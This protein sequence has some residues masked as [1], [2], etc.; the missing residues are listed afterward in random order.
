MMKKFFTL[1]ALVAISFSSMAQWLPQASGFT[2]PSRGIQ[3]MHAASD[4]VVWACAYD[5]SGGGATI[6]EF[7]RTTNGGDLWTPGQVLGGT[8]YGLGNICALDGNIAYVALYK[9]SGN[10]DNTCGVYKTVNGGLTWTQLPGALQGSTSFANNVFFWNEQEG[11]CHGDVRDGY[12]EIYT[13]VNGGTTWQRVPQTSITGGTPASGEGGWTSVI[14]TTGENTVMFGTNKGKVYISD[15]RGFTWRVTSTG[16]TP[17][18]NGGINEIAFTDPDNGIAIQTIAPVAY[19]RTSDGGATWESFT[20]TGPFLTNDLS[21]VP[22][23][24]GTYISTGAAEGFTGIAYSY[25]KG[26]TWAFFPDTEG[27]QFLATDW[28]NITTGWCGA[29]NESNTV[30]GMYKFNGSLEEPLPPTNLQGTVTGGNDVHLTWDAPGGGSVDGFFDDFEDYEDFTLSFS[31]WTN[32]DVDG[33]ETYVIDG[34]TWLNGGDP[35]AYIIFNPMS[36]TP[37]LEETIA[38][39]GTK[40]AA[41]FASVTPPNNDWL[42]SP[43]IMINAGDIADFFAKSYTDQYGLERFKVGISTTGTDPAD[44]TIISAGSYITAPA[45]AYEEFSYDLSAYSGQE[46]YVGIQCVS[47]DA[48]IFLVDDFYVGAP[49]KRHVATANIVSAASSSR[50]VIA[51]NNQHKPNT[52][53]GGER[54]MLG[55]NVWRNGV[56]IANQIADTFYDDMDLANGGYQYL[57][58]AV[59]DN[60]ESTPAGPVEIEITG[61][62][63]LT[64]IIL[65]FEDQADFDLTFG[66]WEAVDL[67]GGATYGFTGITFPHSGEPMAYIAF[68]PAA[69]EPAVTDMEPHGGVRLGACFASVPPAVNDDW[70]ISPQVTLGESPI[71][72]MW[73][74]SYTAEYGLE[75]YNVLVSTTDNNPS[76]FTQIAGPIEAPATAW[77]YV[78]YDLADYQGADVYV[79]IQCVSNDKFIFLI[80]DVAV[81]FITSSGNLPS[82]ENLK[83]YPNPV[84]DVLNINAGVEIINAKLYNVSGQLVYE[85]NGNSN[86][87]R[88]STSVMPSGLYI[89]NIATKQGTL[90]RKVSIQ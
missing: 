22:G 86:E 79:A 55:Y 33:S 59:Y 50:S 13:T 20:P 80:D 58:T 90:T 72:S 6:N 65:D 42:I 19:R 69:T 16:I 82:V 27:I 34:Y 51:G 30:G 36:T 44:F 29:F 11:M 4:Q 70:M 47:N 60:G 63:N 54:E 18:T 37:V 5:G 76:S 57:V 32:I 64:S 17:A 12:F 85:S 7:T 25:D 10:Q 56:M 67:D 28:V 49:G 78:E 45:D 23:T 52:V 35:Q 39:S 46:V 2:T 74:K 62:G 1:M 83:V 21:A 71:L 8:T 26:T 43:K 3:Y 89:L 48:F 84:T 41:C 68:N 38:Y 73:V 31:P 40:V 24:T 81:S 87:M 75:T 15:D 61:G 53:R 77:T 66:E 88:I 9:G 14:E